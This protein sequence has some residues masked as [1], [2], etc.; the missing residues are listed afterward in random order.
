MGLDMYLERDH[1]IG[2][3]FDHRRVTGKI[4]IFV[5]GK[6]VNIDLSKVDT[7]TERVGYWRKAN[8]IHKWFVD[9]VQDGKDDCKR[10]DV[11]YS[12]LERLKALCLEALENKDSGK[13]P[14][15]SGFFFGSTEP[16]DWYWEKIKDTV[17][18]IDKLD[19]EG[20]YY[21]QSSW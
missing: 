4:E 20:D 7:I 14:P 8:Q 12:D 21:Y 16:D 11:G 10:Y 17:D 13:L 2:A 19:P 9:N 1:Y 6:P 3:H 5:A 18:I 15:Q